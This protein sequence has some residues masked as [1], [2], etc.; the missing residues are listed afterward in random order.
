[1]EKR[2]RRGMTLYLIVVCCCIIGLLAG[3]SLFRQKGEKSKSE[4]EQKLEVQKEALEQLKE[5]EGEYNEKNIILSDTTK[6]E[7]EGL[8]E[9]IG[10]KVRV[11]KNG[12]VAVLYLD[13]DK[14]IKQIYKNKKYL[15][16]IGKMD[17]D[18]YG[19][20]SSTSGIKGRSFTSL[21][22]NINLKDT[23]NQTKGS[24]TKIAVID[25]GIDTDSKY[26]SYKISEK[27]FDATTGK[28]VSDYDISV[29]EERDQMTSHGTSVA[30]TRL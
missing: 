4:M 8:A 30:R 3:I 5:D 24:G 18:Y 29:V 12:K 16:Y 14:D 6:A 10:A 28:V 11:T 23:W 13:G 19:T 21:A 22:D 1:M 25:T 26:L 17:P 7:A 2:T 15:N 20:L 9:S 27:S